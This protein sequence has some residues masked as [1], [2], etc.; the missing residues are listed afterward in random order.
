[1]SRSLVQRY[2]YLMTLDGINGHHLFDLLVDSILPQ[3]VFENQKVCQLRSCSVGSERTHRPKAT[4]VCNNFDG[5][6]GCPGPFVHIPCCC[7]PMVAS[8]PYHGMLLPTTV[9][10]LSLAK[11]CSDSFSCTSQ[12]NLMEHDREKWKKEWPGHCL[13]PLKCAGFLKWGYPQIIHSGSHKPSSYWGH[14]VFNHGS[15]MG[16]PLARLIQGST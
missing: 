11:C 6:F 14:P 5:E 12:R 9:C 3:F 7:C 10:R 2:T 1:M 15:T 13:V 8:W 4:L 16:P